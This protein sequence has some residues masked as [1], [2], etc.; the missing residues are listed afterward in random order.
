MTATTF[1]SLGYVLYSMVADLGWS[2]AAAG[3]SFAL[4][5]LACGLGSPLPAILI[6]RLGSRLTL[7]IGALVLASG[8][9]LA[10]AVQG[11]ALFFLATALMGAGFSLIAPSPGVFLIATWFPDRPGRLLG[12][13]F[14]AGSIGGVVGPLIVGAIVTLT[15]SWRVHWA[16]MG[17]SA[18]VLGML[19]LVAVRDAVA[20]ESADQVR[21]AAAA[22]AI[23][24]QPVGWT[25]RRAMMTPSFIVIA[26]AMIIVQT[27]VTTLHSVLVTHV[28]GLGDGG[29]AT[30]GAAAMSMLALTGTL[31]KGATG[32]LAEKYEPKGLLVL[33]LALQCASLILLAATPLASLAIAAALLFGI[34][35]GLAW[36]SAHILLMRYFGRALAGDLTAAAT[37]ATTFAV[38]GP[39]SAGRVADLTG[40]FVPVF[41]VF[42][43]LMALVI[44]T[45]A[46][47]L[48]RPRAIADASEPHPAAAVQ[49]E[50]L[51]PAE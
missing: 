14:M 22:S 17:V 34:G 40:T 23:D 45:T 13:Y 50:A 29:L 21:N 3:T 16:V 42:A 8:F 37:M 15:G 26:L 19:F 35:W 6:R 25:V 28:A 18:L 1:T 24:D 27:A 48:R 2:Q 7:F 51:V 10:S 44:L 49:V 32:A 47:L 41:I 12:Y 39:L 33:G 43:A 11:I 46:F 30:A 4:L 9:F 38:L 20:V 31:A 36:L 5:G